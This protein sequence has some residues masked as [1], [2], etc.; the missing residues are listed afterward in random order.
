MLG[1]ASCLKPEVE[2]LNVL[3]KIMS[4]YPTRRP[5]NM[6]ELNRW[7]VF[8]LNFYFQEWEK[9]YLFGQRE[10]LEVAFKRCLACYLK[11]CQAWACFDEKSLQ[12]S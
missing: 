9:E 1:L 7:G 11:I 2:T 8:L 12:C 3:Q 10:A 6:D 5:V 4:T